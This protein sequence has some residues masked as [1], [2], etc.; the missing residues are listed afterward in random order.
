MKMTKRE[1]VASSDAREPQWSVAEG[2]PTVSCA[3]DEDGLRGNGSE[4]AEILHGLNNAL[5]S[6]LLNAQVIE[7]KLPSYS[8]MKRNLHEIERNAQRGGELVKR[9]LSRLERCAVG[10]GAGLGRPGNSTHLTADLLVGDE[11][12]LCDSNTVNEMQRGV[13]VSSAQLQPV[14]RKKV[15]HTIV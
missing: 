1:H 8:R 15:P 14:A 12:E 11:L 5:V 13:A 7:L 9:L 2:E 3:I 6:M 4:F 10:D